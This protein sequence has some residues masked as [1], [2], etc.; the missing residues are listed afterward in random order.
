MVMEEQVVESLLDSAKLKP[1]K[2]SLDEL[3][4]PQAPR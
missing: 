1:K 3:L 2:M 4:N